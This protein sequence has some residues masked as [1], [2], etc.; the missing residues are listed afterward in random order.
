MKKNIVILYDERSTHTNTVKEHLYSFKDFSRHNVFYVPATNPFWPNGEGYTDEYRTTQPTNLKWSFDSFDAVVV[1]YSVRMSLEG[2]VAPHIADSVRAFR[3]KKILFIQDEYENVETARSNIDDLGFDTIF[4]CVPEDGLEYVYEADTK[5]SHIEFIPTLTGYV[6]YLIDIEAF[7]LPMSLRKNVVAYRGRKLPHHYGLLGYEKYI[8]GERFKE[9]TAKR[10]IKADVETDDL[11]R[12]Y[13]SWYQFLASAR[14]TLGTESGCNIFDF[15][16]GLKEKAAKLSEKPFMQIYGD[17]FAG[18]E[19][20]VKMN[21]ISPKF[22]EAIMLRTALVCFPGSYSG[23]LSRDKHFIQIERDF[24]NLDEVLDKLND[25]QFLTVL[26]ERAFNDIIVPQEYSYRTFIRRF[27]DWLDTQV[28]RS[29]YEIVSTPIGAMK[30]GAFTAFGYQNPSDL[31]FNTTVLAD[32]NDREVFCSLYEHAAEEISVWNCARPQDGAKIKQASPFHPEPNGVETILRKQV[33]GNYAAGLEGKKQFIVIDLGTVRPVCGI[34]L[35][36]L[37]GENLAECF[38]LKGS[39]SGLIW[40]K[41]ADISQNSEVTNSLAIDV[42]LLRYIR[43]DVLGF[44]GQPR[45][46]M[47]GI[48]VL[49]VNTH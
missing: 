5:R 47:R 6:P 32:G 44:K 45:I 25:L 34:N 23:I 35:E 48:E 30:D 49:A 40:K 33:K 46:L 43:L 31:L 42:S 36:W 26:T 13:G 14:S 24:S 11:K 10:G 39:R 8:I 1:H 41:L 7:R 38:T 21:Q 28:M 29:K 27:D 20:A 12:I 4:T 9:E 15:D 18:H 17:S 19:G 3:G 16:G 22:F 2:Y 37:S